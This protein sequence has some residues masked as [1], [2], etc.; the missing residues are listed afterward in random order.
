[1]IQASSRNNSFP[2][3]FDG[4][5]SSWGI[6]TKNGFDTSWDSYTI[7]TATVTSSVETVHA[8]F[9]ESV[10]PSTSGHSKIEEHILSCFSLSGYYVRILRP[11][12]HGPKRTEDLNALYCGSSGGPLVAVVSSL[13]GVA[14]AWQGIYEWPRKAKLPQFEGK[15]MKII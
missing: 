11:S 15:L 3:I 12:P 10:L 8:P 6:I 5:G 1:M 9:S 4:I 2:R 14:W 13:D 7:C